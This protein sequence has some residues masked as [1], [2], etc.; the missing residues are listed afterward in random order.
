MIIEKF[1]QQVKKFPAKTAIKIRQ[2]TLSYSELNTYA[3]RVAH[4]MLAGEQDQAPIGS[5]LKQRVSLFFEH[6]ADMIIGVLAALMAGKTYVPLDVTYPSQ[7]LVYMLEHSDSHLLLT[8]RENFADAAQLVAQTH[9]QIRLLDI[10]TLLQ[11]SDTAES[12]VSTVGMNPVDTPALPQNKDPD[13]PAYI[14]YTSGS[15][16]KPKGVVQTERNIMYY[17]RNWIRRFSLV[18]SDRMTLFSAFSHDGSVQD[19]FAALLT[20]ATLYPYPIKTTDST[21]YLYTLLM[22]EK[23]TV[24]HSVPTLFRYFTTTLTR[25]NVF[26]NVRWV[27]LGGE[28]L[29]PFDLELFRS[30]FPNALLANVYGQTESSVN[31]V[32]TISPKDMFDAVHLGEPLEETEILLAG[33]DGD[34]IE[35]MGVGEIVVNSAYL[36]PGYWQDHA[37]SKNVFTRDDELGRLYWTGDLGR[38]TMD[39]FIKVMGRKDSQVKI[40]GFRV[41][42]GEI[43]SVLL[44]HE[45]VKETVV[46]AKENK[47]FEGYLCAFL[48]TRNSVSPEELRDFLSRQVPDYMIPRF[49]ISLETLPLT[50]NGKIDRHQLPDPEEVMASETE[51]APP[52]NE[53]ERKL[54]VIWQEVLAVERVGSNDH[55]IELGGH[56]LLVISILARVHEEFD[57]ELQLRDVFNNPTVRR[58]ARLIMVSSPTVFTVIN[59]VEEREYYALA[60]AQKRLYAIQQMDPESTAYNQPLIL[61]LRSDIDIPRVEN[62]F[63]QLMKRHE[64]LRTSFLMVDNEP[65]QRVHRGADFKIDYH[66]IHGS[67]QHSASPPEPPAPGA[68]QPAEIIRSFIRPFDLEQAPLLRVGLIKTREQSHLLMVDLHHIIS[69]GMSQEI[70][71]REFFRVYYGEDLLSPRLHYRDYAAWLDSSAVKEAIK[72]QEEYWKKQFTGVL[73]EFALPT[74][75]QRPEIKSFA[76]QAYWF[77]LGKEQ[78]ALLKRIAA[79]EGMTLYMTLLALFTIFLS[80]ISGQEDIILGTDVAGRN[81]S[82]LESTIGMFVNT[83]ALRNYPNPEK[84]FKVFLEEVKENT[85]TAF[86][87]Q[88]YPFEDVLEALKIKRDSSRNPLFDVMFSFLDFKAG[89]EHAM[90]PGIP[91]LAMGPYPYINRT[92]KFDLSL[93]GMEAGE[94]LQLFFEYSTKLFKEETIRRYSGYFCEIVASVTGNPDLQLWEIEV[95]SEAEKDQLIKTVKDE[96]RPGLTEGVKEE[97]E[98]GPA[99]QKAEFD[100]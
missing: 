82:H 37:G 58:L 57:V 100:F 77:D 55:F 26:Y 14:L 56:S 94:S 45:A 49:F 5:G 67:P 91:G 93:T 59:P 28:P 39:G 17:T 81:H 95:L 41:E 97:A 7:R 44:Q 63:R 92:T 48:V 42:T 80:K 72:K 79:G 66:D 22:K 83:L 25:K 99:Q 29:R 90:I 46:I 3:Q 33:E 31:T 61:S 52:A 76:G 38:L 19:M 9:S 27:L 87:N 50:P 96:E 10:D 6:G 13:S 88:D 16:G 34:V 54:I 60:S 84:T 69:D 89:P 32:C 1:Q 8:N 2:R 23:I 40:R 20:G 73:P 36:A 43:E 30:H 18:N 47:K 15:T 35:T 86:A 12:T 4:G 21:N 71:T 53:T 62:T 98:S 51:Y 85:L 65:R 75:Y 11:P 68:V 70:L 64:S 78:T 24:W 74:D